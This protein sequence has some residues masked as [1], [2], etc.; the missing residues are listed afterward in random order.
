M[1]F[2]NPFE[3]FNNNLDKSKNNI[4]PFDND[5][6]NEIKDGAKLVKDKDDEKSKKEFDYGIGFMILILLLIF[7]ITGVAY[8]GSL[9]INNMRGADKMMKILD[10]PTWSFPFVLSMCLI[11]FGLLFFWT[12]VFLFLKFE[13]PVMQGSNIINVMFIVFILTSVL[14]LGSHILFIFFPSFIEIFENTIGYYIISLGIASSQLT[15]RQ[16]TLSEVFGDRLRVKALPGFNIGLEFLITYFTL[17]KFSESFQSFIQDVLSDG[18]KRDAQGKEIKITSISDFS[19]FEFNTGFEINPELI[20]EI[21]IRKSQPNS[22]DTPYDF[23]TDEDLRD[24]G[25][26]PVSF[27]ADLKKIDDF[28]KDL[29]ELTL[30]KYRIGSFCWSYFISV[31]IFIGSMNAFI[32]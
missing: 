2:Q 24:E 16:K 31:I 13:I 17:S 11:T 25:R 5:N 3:L 30:A 10:N 29:F 7:L 21:N 15:T 12:L 27:A 9:E 6:D 22:N 18:T 4:E 14:L 28:K 19:D 8:A 1:K 32:T 23:M 26:E 20:K